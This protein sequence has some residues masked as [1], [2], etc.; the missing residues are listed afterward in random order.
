V[1]PGSGTSAW[2]GK[3]VAVAS[4]YSLET[5]LHLTVTGNKPVLRF[6]HQYDTEAGSDAG[7]V[8]VQDLADPLLQWRRLTKDDAIRGGYDGGVQY[9]TF[10]IPF[11]YGF[12]GNSNGWKQSYFD[13]SAYSGKDITFR[14]RFG[15]DIAVAPVNGAWY[16]DE[17]EIM[18]LFHYAGEACLTAD[19]GDHVCV[20]APEYGVIVQPITVGTHEPN[21]Q[22]IPMLVQ[23]NPA[24]DVLHISLGQA[25][26]GQVVAS[27]VAADGR[28]VLTQTLQGFGLGQVLTLDV[29]NV[30][31][32]MY[33]VHLQSGAGNAVQKVVIR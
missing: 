1:H 20:S 12:S 9:T 23:P 15:S 3:D 30:P 14:F 29:H 22:S 27:L 4:D 26:E 5:T 10:A 32:G 31:A 13:L 17:V 8:E 21:K 11:L 25:L 33:T 6:W 28:T 19:G 18:D 7:F 16:I 24:D 2:A